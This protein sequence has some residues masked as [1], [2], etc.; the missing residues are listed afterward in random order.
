MPPDSV[1]SGPVLCSDRVDIGDTQPPNSAQQGGQLGLPTSMDPKLSTIVLRE[2]QQSRL[3]GRQ[4]GRREEDQG[5]AS[6][7]P[8]VPSTA[9]TTGERPAQIAFIKTLLSLQ[10]F[11]G[12]FKIDIAEARRLFGDAFAE[13][14]LD[15][16]PEERL[17]DTSAVGNSWLGAVAYTMAIVVLL[18]R[19]FHSCE[20]YWTLMR[21]KAA[22]FVQQRLPDPAG[23][24][25]WYDLYRTNLPPIGLQAPGDS[26]VAADEAPSGPQAGIDGGACGPV[27]RETSPSG[28]T[29]S[30]EQDAVHP[31]SQATKPDVSSAPVVLHVAPHDG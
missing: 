12:S 30:T 3:L 28:E 31:E 6:E 18:P 23:L 29:A 13:I 17:P 11:D 15:L 21:M 10:Q 5:A 25:R 24:E 4:G 8:P 1:F 14:V 19:D 20:S 7:T 16:I 9:A 26:P 27:K 2:E 22:E